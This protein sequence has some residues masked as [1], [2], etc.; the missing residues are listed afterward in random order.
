MQ[1]T[2]QVPFDASK[3]YLKKKIQKK[4]QWIW[5]VDCKRMSTENIFITMFIIWC[6][7]WCL[8]YFVHLVTLN[9]RRLT[10]GCGFKYV[11]DVRWDTRSCHIF[12]YS[13]YDTSTPCVGP[14]HFRVRKRLDKTAWGHPPATNAKSFE[15]WHCYIKIKFLSF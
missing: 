12:L 11:A 2:D 4:Y 5:T 7:L 10:R 14:I 3:N 9:N 15:F 13:L 1:H 6:L 8:Y